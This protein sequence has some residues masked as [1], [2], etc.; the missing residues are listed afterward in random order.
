MSRQRFI[1]PDIWRS[2]QFLALSIEARLLFIGI[3]S[4]AD[5]VGRRKASAASL[6]V[7]VFPLDHV[8]PDH[9]LAWRNEIAH[10]GM[11]RL[12]VDKHGV[13][14]LDIPTWTKFQKPKHKSPSR[15]PE[16]PASGPIDLAK[17]AL[18]PK[19]GRSGPAP[20]GIAPDPDRSGPALDETRRG[21]ASGV[22]W[23]GV[24]RCGV[25]VYEP[26]AGK[27]ARTGDVLDQIGI[28]RLA[29]GFLHNWKRR[30]KADDF[31]SWDALW[32]RFFAFERRDPV[33]ALA[34]LIEIDRSKRIK[35]KPATMLGRLR[36]NPKRG[37]KRRLPA[38][39]YMREAK[40]LMNGPR[41]KGGDPEQVGEILGRKKGGK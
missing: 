10:Q 40:L 9:V 38:D 14:V 15:L 5:D 18:P 25:V 36:L 32:Q 29:A 41:G 35:S 1:Y 26:P 23:C 20:D 33:T 13:E 16:Y 22:V 31:K 11:I 37:E 6:K 17:L 12:Y 19:P 27:G 24:E 30:G 2:E 21:G 7:E 39:K 34:H 8:A 4:T 3:F 28:S